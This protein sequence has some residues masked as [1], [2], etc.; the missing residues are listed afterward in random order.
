MNNLVWK[1]IDWTLVQKRVYR[2]QRRIY[3]ASNE[4]NLRK[5]KAIQKRLINSLDAKLIVIKK[6]TTFVVTPLQTFSFVNTLPKEKE[7]E[8]IFFGLNN[9][10]STKFPILSLPLIRKQLKVTSLQKAEVEKKSKD[11][12]INKNELY[13]TDDKKLKLL[14]KLKIDGIVNP[15]KKVS[16]LD[17]KFLMDTILDRAKQYLILL[18]LEPEWE[19]RFESNSYGFRPGLNYYDAIKA[20]YI[21]LNKPYEIEKS[22]N[23]YYIL[24]SNFKGFFDQIDNQYLLNKLA[25]LPI[26]NNQIKAW[27][28]A[29]ILKE[30]DYNAE[31]PISKTEVEIVKNGI[32]EPF[33]T[34]VALHGMEE[35]LNSWISEKSL[36]INNIQKSNKLGIIRYA[37]YFILIH[38]DQKTIIDSKLELKNWLENTSKLKF[39][40]EKSKITIFTKGFSFLGFRFIDI[41]KNGKFKLKIYPNKSSVLKLNH[42]IGNILR[43]Y[44]SVSS[45]TLIQILKPIIIDWCN[46]YSIYQYYETFSKLNHSTYQML[47]AWVFR[48]DKKHGRKIV[49]EKYFESGNTY[50]FQGKKYSDNWVL[51]G[52]KKIENGKIK[53]N[54]LPK[55]TWIKSKKYIK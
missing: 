35:H 19:A 34:N 26:I 39:N 43:K 27:L 37:E 38:N 45:Y 33:L 9:S 53:R 18:A 41:K 36:S 44:R 46:Y 12:N 22:R 7:K 31:D 4:N 40:E 29:G 16:K 11:N 55:F 6:V 5:I 13:Y 8:E 28:E 47:R 10:F 52:Y 23:T 32:I 48:R 54:F 21:F 2:Y 3:K 24:C 17:E 30:P 50:N 20:I 14:K 25:A 49:K 1:D 42:K 15:I 51:V